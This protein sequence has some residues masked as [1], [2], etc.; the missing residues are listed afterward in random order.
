MSA[1][2]SAGWLA[3]L[4]AT[5]VVASGC[6]GIVNEGASERPDFQLILEK[7]A[8]EQHSGALALVITKKGL[9]RGAA[10]H[11]EGKRRADPEDR[12]G[13]ASTTKTFV[14]TVVLQLVSEGR[15]SLEDT[16]ERWLPGRVREGRRI[17]IRQLL[18]HTSGL[19]QDVSFAL[20][21]RSAQ[22]PLLSRPGTTHS[23]S[24]LNYVILGLVVEK[25][26]GRRL[27]L[28]VRDR[29]FRPL[30]LTDSSYG[31]TT[32]HAHASRRRWLG[33]PEGSAG[34]SGAAGI[35][36]TA[37]DLATFFRALLK[38]D[39]IDEDVLAEMM[40]TVSTGTEFR[41]GLGLFRADLRCGSA[42]G[43]GGD[44]LGYSNHVLVSRDGS[45]IVVVAQNTVGWPSVRAKAE[46][47]YCRAL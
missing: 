17:T 15:L 7:L 32:L 9:W 2:S 31:T 13:I 5:F 10:G 39:L 43:H 40:R 47:M 6:G 22:Q 8:H 45:T 28:V 42:W 20:A 36:S 21:P 1:R 12:F 23:Y 11:A 18:N 33:V 38:G 4:V 41:A 46:E 26:A 35:V 19:P 34:V 3:P 30:A 44:D 14:A 25:V 29:I 27:D 16:V 37:D 24:N